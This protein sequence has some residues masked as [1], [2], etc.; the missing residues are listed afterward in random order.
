MG[1]VL[2]VVVNSTISS[3]LYQKNLTVTFFIYMLP[4]ICQKSLVLTN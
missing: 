3:L 4:D 1:V 2:V